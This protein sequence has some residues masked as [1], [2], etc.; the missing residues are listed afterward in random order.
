MEKTLP[1]R[2][3][4]EN[5][6][7]VAFSTT[8][9]HDVNLEETL[10]AN[11]EEGEQEIDEFGKRLLCAYDSHFAEVNDIIVERLRGWTLARLPRV[12]ATA[13]R[14]AIAEMLYVGEKKP[15]VAINEAVELVKKYGAGD[16]YQ[17]VN[18]LLGSVARDFNLQEDEK[19]NENS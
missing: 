3:S 8:F 12:S 13:L 7:L 14:L 18:G 2:Q 16:D 17:F 6:F 10:V 5:A 15:S 1:R 11:A 4:R 9:H 19:P